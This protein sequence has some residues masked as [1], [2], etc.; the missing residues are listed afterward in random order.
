VCGQSHPRGLR[1]RFFCRGD[2]EVCAWFQPDATLT[3]YDDVVHGGVISALLDE[4]IGWTISLRKDLLVCTAEFSVRFKKPV[5][6]GKRYLA[7]ARM[8][9]GRGLCWEAEGTLSDTDGQVCV[10][11]SGRYFLLSA[12]Q[13]S[14]MAE[15]MTYEPG[16]VPVFHHGDGAA[17]H[18]TNP[19]GG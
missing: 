9:S 7:Q 5:R 12:E 2:G 13:T 10:K 1:I 4:L 6:P 19:L 11:G 14:Q 16:D 18:K 8:V 17:R 3:G 15:K